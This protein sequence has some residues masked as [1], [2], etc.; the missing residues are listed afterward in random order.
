MY[1]LGRCHI[2]IAQ[3]GECGIGQQLY[4]FIFGVLETFLGLVRPGLQID[5]VALFENIVVTVH[6]FLEFNVLDSVEFVF[7]SSFARHLSIVSLFGFVGLC[8]FARSR[9]VRSSFAA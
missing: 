5:D 6:H 9:F 7:Q 2:L 4:S 8:S 1:L 3:V